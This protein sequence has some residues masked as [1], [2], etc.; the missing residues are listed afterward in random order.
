MNT[1]TKEPKQSLNQIASASADVL[2]VM[3]PDLMD[4]EDTSRRILEYRYMVF[5]LMSAAGYKHEQIAEFFKM[6]RSSITNAIGKMEAWRRIY[7]DMEG[8]YNR[9][10]VLALKQV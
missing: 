10:E 1:T 3:L 7:K 5:C 4:V 8:T 9:L 6:K 2:M